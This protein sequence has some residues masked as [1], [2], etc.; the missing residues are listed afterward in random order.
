[1]MRL[2]IR[3]FQVGIVAGSI[4]IALVWAGTVW[5]TAHRARSPDDEALY[6]RC[7]VSNKG[8]TVACDAFI[9][10]YDR[11][12]AK[13]A[14]LE[15][16]LKEGGAKMLAAGHSKREVVDWAASMGGVGSQ[17]SDAAGISLKDLQDG[18]Y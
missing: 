7:M 16:T 18:K 5:W 9:R 1:M 4:L 8:N 10:T 11:E 15:K 2:D 3:S 14:A 12:R 17:L 6:D 13:D